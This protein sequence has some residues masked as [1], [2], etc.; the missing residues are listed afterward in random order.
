[1]KQKENIIILLIWLI[2]VILGCFYHELWRDETQVWC[3]VRDLN[4]SQIFQIARIEGHPMLWYMLIFPFAKLGLPVE[5]MQVL[6]VAFVFSSLIFLF[7]KSP[8]TILQKILI[9]FSAGMVYFLPVIARNYALIPLFLFLLAHFY[10]QRKE[11]PYVYS[12]L[13]I[14]LSQ[15]HVLMLGF[16]LILFIIFTFEQIKTKRAFPAILLLFINFAFLFFSFYFAQGSNK[17]VQMYSQHEFTVFSLLNDFCYIFFSPAFKYSALVNNILFYGFILFAMYSF[18]KLEKK[19]FFIFTAGFLYI[20]Y[21][22]AKVWFGGVSYQKAFVLT[23]ILIFCMWIAE[24]KP[25]ALQVAFNFFL[26]LSVFLATM[27]LYQEI[28]YPFSASRQTANYIKENIKAETI[29][30]LGE[31][32]TISPLSAYLPNKKFY[33]IENKNYVSYFDFKKDNNLKNQQNEPQ[34]KYYVVQTNA[35]LF[36]ELGYKLIFSSEENIIGPTMEAEVYKIYEKI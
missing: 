13:L 27:Y 20:F 28:K 6:S 7:Y 2:I 21:I 17:T 14:L 15:T 9:S 4:F 1:M 33:S 24:N 26:G 10:N 8:F 36:E 23:L 34:S 29:N 5:S 25:K 35:F 16:C 32:C 30:F 3:I 18:F 11:K 12:L 31:S 22:Y 19:V